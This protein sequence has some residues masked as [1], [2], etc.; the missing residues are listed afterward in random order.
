MAKNQANELARSILKALKKEFEEEHLTGNFLKSISVIDT[1]EFTE[2]R[3]PAPSYDF[4]EYFINGVIIPPTQG[5]KPTS[6]ASSLDLFGSELDIYWQNKV[7]EVGY[8]HIEPGNHEGYVRKVI[9]AG[10]K[11]WIETNDINLASDIIYKI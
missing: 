5:G 10:I 2:I 7:G 8:K 4:Y 11:D 3:I 6:Y 9:L 1:N